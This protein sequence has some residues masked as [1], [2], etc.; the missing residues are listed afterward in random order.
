L[1][2]SKEDHSLKPAQAKLAKQA[3]KKKVV[4]K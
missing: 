2:G 1:G 3:E 4:Q